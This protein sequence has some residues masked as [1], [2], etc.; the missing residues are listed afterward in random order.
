MFAGRRLVETVNLNAY[1]GTVLPRTK[2]TTFMPGTRYYFEYQR[3][4][5]PMGEPEVNTIW[6]P[7]T[8]LADK[9][10]RPQVSFPDRLA[11]IILT[12]VGFDD[13]RRNFE[14]IRGSGIFEK[15]E[16]V[17]SVANK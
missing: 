13:F 17:V 8:P 6:R 1:M 14:R 15:S 3:G 5:K 7:S 12:R 2:T 4:I 16:N 10:I 11:A 9:I